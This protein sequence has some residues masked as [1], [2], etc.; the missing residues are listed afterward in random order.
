MYALSYGDYIT[1]YDAIYMYTCVY[2]Y[3]IDLTDAPI[4]SVSGC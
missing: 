1:N 4:S 2:T 3:E